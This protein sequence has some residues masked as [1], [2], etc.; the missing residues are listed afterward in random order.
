M[1]GRFI[2]L[3]LKISPAP[4]SPLHLSPVPLQ[5]LVLLCPQH[6]HLGLLEKLRH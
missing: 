1:D 3:N 4:P 6:V 2:S 5:V